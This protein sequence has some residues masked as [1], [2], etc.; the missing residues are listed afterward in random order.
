MA[1]FLPFTEQGRATELV[2][3]EL[4]RGLD[5]APYSPVDPYAV[6]PRVPAR[7]L[8]TEVSQILPEEIRSCLFGRHS[9]DW[10]A[11][12]IGRSPA[13]GEE[14]I[15]V[16]HTHHEHRRRVSIMEEIIH[17]LR[18]HPRV[19]L[20]FTADGRWK[21]AYDADSEDEA[22]NVGAACILPYRPLFNRIKDG[23]MLAELAAG[24]D[25]SEEY[26]R[27][28]IKRAGLWNMFRGRARDFQRRAPAR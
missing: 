25:V 6:L 1:L 4:K 13:S 12:G 22:Y 16:N 19:P 2:A 20:S 23:A 7:V 18:E 5:L 26:V 8:D 10:S 15:L 27:F 11:V 24:A 9:S 14:L 21:R 17:I 3:I 28:R